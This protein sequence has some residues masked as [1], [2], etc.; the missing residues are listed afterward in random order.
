[1]CLTCVRADHL[2]ITAI[3]VGLPEA[4]IIATSIMHGFVDFVIPAVTVIP[5]TH[6]HTHRSH[7]HV[8]LSSD[9]PY[10]LIK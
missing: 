2:F 1:M 4:C 3:T 10:H 6:T 9:N 5:Y 8:Y 7:S